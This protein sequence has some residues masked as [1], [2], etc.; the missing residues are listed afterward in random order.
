MAL[1]P[2]VLLNYPIPEVR[3]RYSRRDSA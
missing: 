3:Q 2:E 1:D